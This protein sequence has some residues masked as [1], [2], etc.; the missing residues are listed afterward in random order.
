MIVAKAGR[1]RIIL[2]VSYALVAGIYNFMV[3][4]IAFG[5]PWSGDPDP[6]HPADGRF[7]AMVALLLFAA[8]VYGASVRMRR[9]WFLAIGNVIAGVVVVW[10]S[11]PTPGP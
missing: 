6:G 9:W 7:F 8:A 1:R 3:A 11:L 4:D 5:V 10:A 2:I